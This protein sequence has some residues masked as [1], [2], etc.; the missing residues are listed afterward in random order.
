MR[1]NFSFIIT[2]F[3]AL[4]LISGTVGCSLTGP[5]YK[6]TS[7]AFSNPFSKDKPGDGPSS[8]WANTTAPPL[9]SSES[10][11]N[12]GTPPGGHTGAT[13][14]THRSGDAS[15]PP[16]HWGAENPMASQ[17]LSN[18]HGGFTHPTHPEPSQHFSYTPPQVDHFG[19]HVSHSVAQQGQNQFMFQPQESLHHMPSHTVSPH[20]AQPHMAQSHMAQSHM[21]QPHMVQPQ[22]PSMGNM[23]GHH[24]GWGEQPNHT[25]QP[26]APAWDSQPIQQHPGGMPQHDGFGFPPQSMN[27][28]P[29]GFGQG[30]MPPPAFHHDQSFG[31]PAPQQAPPP[32]FWH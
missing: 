24:G 8:F 32:Q 1:V 23:P 7:Y 14:L 27:V 29:A 28:P 20:T 26:Q 31:M 22:H 19:Q 11:P 17:G 30:Q 13:S 5:W 10:Q 16:A 9:P 25:W 15:N 21:V 2:A 6:P 18:V 4:S 12:L 3:V